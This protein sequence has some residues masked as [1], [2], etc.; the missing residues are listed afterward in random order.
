MMARE[1]RKVPYRPPEELV[2]IP[3]SQRLQGMCV[4]YSFVDTFR[5]TRLA[6][7]FKITTPGRFFGLL[8]PLWFQ[9]IEVLKGG[10]WRPSTHSGKYVRS[11]YRANPEHP[12]IKRRDR[13]SVQLWGN[14]VYDLVFRTVTHDRNQQALPKQCLYSV[15]EAVLPEGTQQ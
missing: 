11:F 5:S 15:L 14:K 13:F 6:L 3:D 8:V 9:D 1:L 2:L 12:V 10:R 7:Q 4:S